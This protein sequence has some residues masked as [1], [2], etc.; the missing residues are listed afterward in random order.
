[1]AFYHF[2]QF[3]KG[4]FDRSVI[5]MTAMLSISFTIRNTSPIGWMPLLAI[6][7]VKDGAFIP[8]LKA[9][10]LIF[11]PIIGLSIALDSLYYG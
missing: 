8:Y 9:G 10:F 5:I 1:M 2:L 11:F 3:K 6:R 4:V 7:V